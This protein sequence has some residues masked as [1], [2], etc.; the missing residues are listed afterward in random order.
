MIDRFVSNGSTVNLCALDMSKAFDR[1]SHQGLFIKLMNKMIPNELL[2]TFE[3]WFSIC[4]TSVRW[5]NSYSE[6]FQL[7][8]GV[9]QGGVLSPYLF[10]VFIDDIF[11][12]VHNS[13]YGCHFGCV[14]FSIFLYADDIML[15]APSVFGLQQLTLTVEC[16]LETCGMSLNVKKSC[17]LRIG[18]RHMDACQS[19]CTASGDCIQWVNNLRYLGTQIVAAKKFAI[20][21]M[22]N[23]KSYY[24]SFN[25]ISSQLKGNASEECYIKLIYSKCVPVLLYG[26]EI[27][28][29]KNSQ[30]RHLEFLTRRTLMRVFKT[31]SLDIIDECMSYFNIQLYSELVTARQ[32][33]FLYKLRQCENSVCLFLKEMT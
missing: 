21:L 5:A 23:V 15:I 33:N 13:Q 22:E 18:P 28:T 17:C 3:Y 26:L 11:D 24:K 12:V 4:C 16:F 7:K 29:L 25:V 27:C 19:I 10:S 6:F 30:M 14:N 31:S 32:T 20:S 9:R 2:A 1:M 8:C